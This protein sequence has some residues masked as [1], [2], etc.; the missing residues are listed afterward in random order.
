MTSRPP[1]NS[2]RHRAELD[3]LAGEGDLFRSAVPDLPQSGLADPKDAAEIWG[4]RIGRGLG[5]I[6]LVGLLF[7]LAATYL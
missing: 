3:R 7:W 2:A 1:D 5:W 6:L 4:R